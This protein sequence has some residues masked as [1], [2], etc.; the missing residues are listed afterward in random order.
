MEIPSEM[1]VDLLVWV[2]AR[3]GVWVFP[4]GAG[5]GVVVGRVGVQV[6]QVLEDNRQGT[7]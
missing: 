3:V 1:E 7:L 4:H 6:S 5:L 2:H